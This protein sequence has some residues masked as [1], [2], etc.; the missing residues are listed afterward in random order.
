MGGNLGDVLR[1]HSTEKFIC[2][3]KAIRF[4]PLHAL[5]L[6]PSLTYMKHF[7]QLLSNTNQQWTIVDKAHL[8]Y[9]LRQGGRAVE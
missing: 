2:P 9:N 8:H 1:Y 5:A 7:K 6:C 4:L 3:L